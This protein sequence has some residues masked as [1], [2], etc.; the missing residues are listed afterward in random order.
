VT[1][2]DAAPQD[3]V[4]GG[5]RVPAP[6]SALGGGRLLLYALPNITLSI[7]TLPL[8]IYLPAFYSQNL[9]LPL[10]TVGM[11]IALSRLTDVVTDPLIGILSDRHKTRWGRRKPWIALG[12]PLMVAALWMLYVP[13]DAVSAWWLFGFVALVY[14]AYTLIDLPYRA[15]GAELSTDYAMRSRVTGWREGFGIIG[16]LLALLVPLLMQLFLGLTGTANALWGI[17]ITV[18]VLL[19]VL[20]VGALYAV[21][22]PEQ[23]RTKAESISWGRGLR[24]VWRNGPFIRLVI[25]GLILLTAVNM[26]ASLSLLFVSHVMLE[27]ERFAMFIFLYYIASFAGIPIWLRI[28]DRFGKHRTVALAIFWLSLWSAPIPLL[29][30]GDFYLFL[31]LMLLKGSSVG[32]LVFLPVSMAADV[33]DIDTLRSGE[34]RTGLYF[35]I[36]GMILKGAVALGVLLSTNGAALAGFDPR[37]ASSPELF[38]EMQARLGDAA[39]VNEPVAL[40]WLAMLYSIIPAILALASLPYLWSYPVTEARQQR[41]RA[42]IARRNLALERT[43]GA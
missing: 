39:C 17:A 13:P 30:A 20:F 42:R 4:E 27:P 3:A 34:Q 41:L 23:E 7:V 22:E 29:G 33:V 2:A 8:A 35:A 43:T 10:A 6:G 37:C 12:V 15:W 32:A 16:V 11:F 40:L 9:G 26:T 19:P 36:W 24:V 38:A 1:I 25:V 18:A 28:S 5:A 31:V 14:L 21:P